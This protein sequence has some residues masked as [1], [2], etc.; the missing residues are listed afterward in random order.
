MDANLVR[1]SRR[2]TTRAEFEQ[3][4]ASQADALREA[5]SRGRFDGGFVVGL[6]LEGYTVNADGRLAAAPESAFGTICE[7]ELG[8]H[9]A[10]L[11]T[12]ATAFD[13]DGFDE[14]ADAITDGVAALRRACGA[15]DRR[16]ITDGMWT[17]P[18][19][20]GTLTYLTAVDRDGDGP[21]PANMASGPR[22]YALDADITAHGPVE[23][24][25]PGCRRAF[26]TILVESLATSMQVHLQVPTD[27]FPQYFNAALRTAGPVLALAANAPFLPP[28]LYE[29]SDDAGDPVLEGMAALRIPVFEAM[30]VRDPGKVRFPHDITSPADAIDLIV[31]DRQ[32]VPWLREWSED[33]P[34]EGFADEY[35]ELLHKQSTCWRWIRPILGPEGPRIEYRPLAAQPSV[36]D[37]I[38]LQA[39]VVGL[40]HGVVATDHP[41]STLSWPAARESF[42]AASRD[43]LEADLAWITRRGGRTSDPAVIYDELFA[44]ARQGLRDRGLDTA[45]V[46]ALL[47]PLEARWTTTTSPS[48]WKRD[49]VRD[50]LDAGADLETAITGMQRT[51]HRRAETDTPFVDW[52]E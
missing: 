12:P 19:P 51:Y 24:D 50:R 14:Q 52:L 20:E 46:E 21:R 49:Q 39:L 15:A 6:E 31:E 27:D 38:A 8:R 2:E 32:C 48:A 16:F 36:A 41:V 40:L 43:G 4:V 28:D 37:V 29:E 3:R 30:N 18:P 34:R 11:N 33:G 26:P 9:N 47:A 25:V 45:R 42:Y 5:F 35:W 1:A 44:L 23:L 13:A 10:E 22:Y 17:I 7:R